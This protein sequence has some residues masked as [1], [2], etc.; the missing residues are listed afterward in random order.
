MAAA[1]ELDQITSDLFIWHRYDPAVKAELFSTG[2]RTAS[3]VWLID[4]IPVDR[5]LL[6]TAI[7]GAGIRG[8]IV[9]NANHGRSAGELS[10]RLGVAVHAHP[11]A[12]L[13]S[14]LDPESTLA[15]YTAIGDDLA[16]IPIAGAPAGEIAL[17]SEADRGTLVIGDALIN[18]DAYGFTFL[19]AKYCENPKLMRKSLRRLLDY[20]FER[21]LFAHGAPIMTGGRH[22]LGELLAGDA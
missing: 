5:S 13:E 18:I 6:E 4:P 15:S 12:R 14:E 22:R 2:L 21:L 11:D 7:G 19:P 16:L 20:R 8:I 17:F 3:G 9:T 1:P 10:V